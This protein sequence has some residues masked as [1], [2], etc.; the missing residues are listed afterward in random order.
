[1]NKVIGL[2]HVGWDES[3]VECDMTT[4]PLDDANLDVAV[5]SLSLMGSNWADYLKEAYRTVKPYGHLFIAEPAGRWQGRS[6]E[7][8]A[9]VEGAGFRPLGDVEQRY[10]FIYVTAVKA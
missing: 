8:K 4:T 10:D 9:A 5:F 2:D 7:L 3:V 6:E 1:M